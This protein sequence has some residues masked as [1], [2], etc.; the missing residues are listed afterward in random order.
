[1]PKRLATG[2]VRWLGAHPIRALRWRPRGA[3]FTLLELLV[4][5]SIMVIAVAAFPIALNR[6]LPGSRV[7]A[8]IE[9][10]EAAVR[11][12][13]IRSIALDQPQRLSVAELTLQ[14]ATST[15]LKATGPDGESLRALVTYPDGSTNG[16]RFVV[17]DG[18]DRATVIVGEITGRI[19]VNGQ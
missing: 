17:S 3:G 1:M 9:H 7:H 11:R 13:E 19:D 18:S 14:V 12:T 15:H 8:A 16:A 10:V 4:V 6:A 5:L 2:S